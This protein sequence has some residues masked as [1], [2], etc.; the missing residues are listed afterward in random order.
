[1]ADFRARRG[2]GWS[3]PLCYNTLAITNVESRRCLKM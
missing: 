3:L 1:M 2:V